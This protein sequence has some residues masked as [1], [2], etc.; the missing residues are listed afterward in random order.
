MWRV[1]DGQKI[2]VWKDLWLKKPPN[3]KVTIPDSQMPTPLKVAKLI[4]SEKRRWDMDIVQEI[5]LEE[6][7]SLIT[8]IPLSKRTS[9][10]QL[11]WRDSNIGMLTVK[12]A[13]GDKRS[14]R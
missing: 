9:H 1:G 2:D 5:F 3:F 12:Y 8:S 4:D 10:D 7:V 6:G 11:I 13:C 14:S